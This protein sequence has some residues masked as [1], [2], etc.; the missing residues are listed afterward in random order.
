MS[1]EQRPMRV[2]VITA[3]SSEA[4]PQRRRGDRVM[5]AVAE[6]VERNGIGLAEAALY[7]IGSAAGGALVAASGILRKIG[8]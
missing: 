7:L 2:R 4:V 5:T 8:L 6:P 3:T 1:D